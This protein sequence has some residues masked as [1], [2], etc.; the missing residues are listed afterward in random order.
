MQVKFINERRIPRTEFLTVS[1]YVRKVPVFVKS[2]ET[3]V[4]ISQVF[5]KEKEVVPER[6]APLWTS[7]T[8]YRRSS[9]FDD[10]CEH[11]Q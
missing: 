1:S 7:P 9:V 11:A 5:A 3:A 6:L 2:E 8:D 10:Q 4:E